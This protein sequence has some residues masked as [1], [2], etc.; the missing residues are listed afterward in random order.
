MKFDA[1][2]C[3]IIWILS[4][5]SCSQLYSH[6]QVSSKHKS[7]SKNLSNSNE[8]PKLMDSV[9]TNKEITVTSSMHKVPSHESN[10]STDISVSTN[11]AQDTKINDNFSNLETPVIISRTTIRKSQLDQPESNARSPQHLNAETFLIDKFK[12][13]IEKGFQ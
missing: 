9:Y 5:I 4:S 13:A 2:G 1:F 10:L 12:E 7:N 3:F 6:S 11:D 8:H